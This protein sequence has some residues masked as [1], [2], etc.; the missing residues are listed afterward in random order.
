MTRTQLAVGVSDLESVAGKI[1]FLDFW[2]TWC[3]PCRREIPD[4][5]AFSERHKERE[6]FVFISVNGD[7][8]TS[9]TGEQYVKEFLQLMRIN[10]VVLLDNPESSLVGRLGVS[11]WPSSSC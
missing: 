10:Y 7:P 11:G 9:G 2:A 4:L 5:I 3:G 8:V 6:D 1:V